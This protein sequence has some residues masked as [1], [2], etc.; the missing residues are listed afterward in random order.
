MSHIIEHKYTVGD[1]IQFMYSNKVTEGKIESVQISVNT[2][3][4]IKIKGKDDSTVEKEVTIKV[5]RFERDSAFKYVA[6][7]V[8]FGPRIPNTPAHIA[9][10]NYLSSS[11]KS[12][13]ADVIEPPTNLCGRSRCLSVTPLLV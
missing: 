4:K 12:F 10:Q 13:G 9:C 7:Q 3:Q 8:A 11:L 2:N 5:P 6:Q 1:F